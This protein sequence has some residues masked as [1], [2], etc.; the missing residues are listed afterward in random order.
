MHQ[1]KLEDGSQPWA[2]YFLS[3]HRFD[4]GLLH[5]GLGY[6]AK[7]KVHEFNEDYDATEEFT[8]QP[9][10]TGKLNLEFY[11]SFG[12]WLFGIDFKGNVHKKNAQGQQ[13]DLASHQDTTIR[14]GLALDFMEMHPSI[15]LEF[16]S[17]KDER[18]ISLVYRSLFTF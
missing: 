13:V 4:D 3:K 15:S 8:T 11:Q 17:D 12:R 16:N 10:W 2:F 14:F 5:L 7:M 18:F 9:Y 1:G 6:F